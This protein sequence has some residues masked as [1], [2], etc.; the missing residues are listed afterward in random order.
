MSFIFE[1]SMTNK[2][3]GLH[4]QTLFDLKTTGC[5]LAKEMSDYGCFNKTNFKKGHF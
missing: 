3:N 1:I 5:H 2:K 4:P